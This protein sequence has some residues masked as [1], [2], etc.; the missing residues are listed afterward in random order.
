MNTKCPLLPNIG[1]SNDF[2]LDNYESFNTSAESFLNSL[3]I[4]DNVLAYCNIV[5]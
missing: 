2:I 1:F 5:F 3:N 4:N